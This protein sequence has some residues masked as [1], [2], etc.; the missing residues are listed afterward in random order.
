MN[1]FPVR[2][3]NDDG[4]TREAVE[5]DVKYL[6]ALYALVSDAAEAEELMT[7]EELEA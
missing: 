2:F 4:T 3:L 5:A 6:D 1:P 7:A